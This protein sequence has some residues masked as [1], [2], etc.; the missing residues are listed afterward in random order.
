MPKNRNAAWAGY[1]ERITNTG[2]DGDVLWD[3]GGDHEFNSYLPL[4]LR[5]LNPAL[6][7]VDV[8]SGHGSF[9]RLLAAHFPRAIGVDVAP[10][11]TAR[12][13]ALAEPMTVPAVDFRTVDC[14]VAGAGDQLAA[15]LGEANVFVRGVFHVLDPVSRAALAAN[16]HSLVGATGRVFL[17]ETNYRGDS[18]GY[19]S[20]LGA[21]PGR[22]PRPLKLAI[23]GLPKPGHFG[24][25]ERKAAFDDAAWTVLE[26][27][28]V[29]ID[30]V[31]MRE[32]GQPE[33]IPGY[34]AALAPRNLCPGA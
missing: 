31:A 26:D 30:A 21:T 9:T 7:V 5:T 20:R 25:G 16:L 12:A 10:G 13:L 22:I 3:A 6:P 33:Q 24:P 23:E 28:A 32:K 27:G 11:A 34:Y 19:I 1:W 14:T 4:L 29:T 15:E 18:L 2:A 8:G 17:I